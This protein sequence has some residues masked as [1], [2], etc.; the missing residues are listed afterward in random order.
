MGIPE[1]INNLEDAKK[2][3]A[4]DKGGLINAFSNNDLMQVATAAMLSTQQYTS[5]IGKWDVI[6]PC[7]LKYQES[8]TINWYLYL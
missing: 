8:G 6:E 3:S 5:T 1:Y 7:V 4:R 2:C